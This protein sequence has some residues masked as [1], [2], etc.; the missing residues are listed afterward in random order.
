MYRCK[1]CNAEYLNKPEYCDC[2]NNSFEE[3]ESFDSKEFE[4]EGVD[5]K[6]SRKKVFFEQYPKI[7]EI[8]DSLDILSTSIFVVC[9]ILS[10]LSWVFIGKEDSNIKQEKKTPH[11]VQKQVKNADI[12]DI[13]S[14][15]NS[16]PPAETKVI[17]QPQVQNPMPTPFDNVIEPPAPTPQY[18]PPLPKPSPIVMPVRQKNIVKPSTQSQKSASSNSAMMAYKNSLRQVLFSHLAVTSVQGVG[19][20]EIE[21]SVDKG[22]RLLNRRFSKLSDNKSLNDAVY[23]MLMSVPQF[24][25]PPVEYSGEKIRLNFSFDNG[26]YE[27]SY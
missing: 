2:G 17:E 25:P 12:P 26:Y 7:K 5:F 19:R 3:I 4:I 9:I 6:K 16:T 14:F 1:D 22:G 8:L 27:V 24:S 23:N 13:D 21:F 15:W 10:I 20:C 11:H 18:N